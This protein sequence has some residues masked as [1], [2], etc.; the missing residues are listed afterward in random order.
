MTLNSFRRARY[1]A[2]LGML[3]LAG[4]CG[5]HVC[6]LIGSATGITLKF[7]PSAP[8]GPL[9][10]EVMPGQ[11]GA[12]VY[13]CTSTTA[14]AP[15]VNISDYYPSTITVKVTYQ[16]RVSTTSL[17]PQYVEAEVNGPGCG[18]AR[19]ATITLTLP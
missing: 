2:T 13:D 4:G 14:C 3:S 11:V 5:D 1:F 12:F 17:T 10:I 19:S 15:F 18:K 7:V 6:T 16:G 9:R 8:A